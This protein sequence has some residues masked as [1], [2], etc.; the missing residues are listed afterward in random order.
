MTIEDNVFIGPCAVTMNDKYPVVNNPSYVACPPYLE[1]H[2]SIGAGAVILPG[3]RVGR[4]SMVGAGAVVTK[5]VAP[6]TLVVGCPATHKE[7]LK[8]P[9][10]WEER[11]H[12]CCKKW[13][14]VIC[15][16][17]WLEEGSPNA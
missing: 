3:V 7:D 1:T 11:T 17:L 13:T 8:C 14:C 15:E 5:D 9:H 6:L 4:G 10:K 12:K 16:K 2:C